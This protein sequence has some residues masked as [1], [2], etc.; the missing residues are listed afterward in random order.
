M[1]DNLRHNKYRLPLCW[2]KTSG[3]MS[4][5]EFVWLFGFR[6]A[7]PCL[8]WMR[9]LPLPYGQIRIINW[10]NF[11]AHFN[12]RERDGNRRIFENIHACLC[13]NACKRICFHWEMREI[14]ILKHTVWILLLQGVSASWWKLCIQWGVTR[15]DIRHIEHII[16]VL[17]KIKN[18][19][20]SLS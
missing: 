9:G 3:W 2:H 5:S 18:Q 12:I 8:G 7:F 11:R 14:V 6:Y 1:L 16:I 20:Q 19:L 15:L 17:N 13:C 10:G 4:K